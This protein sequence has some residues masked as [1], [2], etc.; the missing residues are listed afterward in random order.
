MRLIDADALKEKLDEIRKEEIAL[1]G[2]GNSI[3]CCTLSTALT[4]INDAP[5]IEPK[6]I[7]YT[8]SEMKIL[9]LMF[10]IIDE[11]IKM[12]NG[13]MDIDYV[14]FDSGDLYNLANKLGVE[15]Y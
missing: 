14:S 9:G 7:E 15:D 4:E 2:V 1:Y 11:I 5:T 10:R 8:E 13:Y 12:Q 3:F 6:H